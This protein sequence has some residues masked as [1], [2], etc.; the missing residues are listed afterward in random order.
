MAPIRATVNCDMGEGYSLYTMGDD[1]SLMKTI[2]LANIAC[3]FH[4][5]D[6]SIMDK[7]VQLAKENN[8]LVG[9]HPSLPDRQGFGR[10]EMVMEPDELTAC[11]TYQV[12]ALAGFLKQH[13]MKLNHV[14]PHGAVYGQLARSTDLSKA[15]I[16]VCKT[17]GSDVAFMG[18]AGTAHQEVAVE[19]GVKF[20]AEWFADLDY[21]PEGKLLITKKHVPPTLDQVRKRVTAILA[22]R[23]ITTNAGTFIALPAGVEEVSICVHSDTPGAVEIAKLVKSLV[24]ESNTKAGYV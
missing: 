19:E 12:G 15:A 13:G 9:A 21:S 23:Q 24:D 18:L 14:K 17:F 16:K 11:F 20:I 4:A 22:N 1:E 6:F 10:R 3:G 8:V 7:T 5:S 2:H